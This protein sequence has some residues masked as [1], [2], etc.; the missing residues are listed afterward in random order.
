MVVH[1]ETSQFAISPKNEPTPQN[2]RYMS[3]TEE[4][5]QFVILPENEE[6]AMNIEFILMTEETFHFEMSGTEL[7][8]NILCMV[9]TPDTAR[10][11]T[12]EQ[13]KVESRSIH[14]SG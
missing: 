10:E 1:D 3:L 7:D 13:R 14:V 4:T 8:K 12:G 2:S 11:Q 9:V 5:S 6:E